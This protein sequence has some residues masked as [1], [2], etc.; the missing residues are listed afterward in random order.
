MCKQQ[1]IGAACPDTLG[2][3]LHT[4]PR[5]PSAP[6]SPS[7][8][9]G[10]PIPHCHGGSDPHLNNP[11]NK[12]PNTSYQNAFASS[13][14]STPGSAKSSSSFGCP[15]SPTFFF[16][17]CTGVPALP[18]A[19]RWCDTE[20]TICYENAVD[21]V[22]YACGHMCL[23]YACGLKLKKMNNACCPICRRAI[24]DIIKTYRST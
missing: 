16:P 14:G 5:G 10:T 11:H 21:T 1:C 12:S 13:T 17:A 22:L 18:P 19:P 20:C 15:E 7:S 4:G 3:S 23:C 24:K 6:G 8:A 2:S 9:P